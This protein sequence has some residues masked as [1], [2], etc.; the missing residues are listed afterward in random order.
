MALMA[1]EA[2][3]CIAPIHDSIGTHIAYARW[4]RTA[5]KSCIDRVD[6]KFLDREILIPSKVTPLNY[7]GADR[8]RFAKSRHILG[9]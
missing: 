5:F 7:P 8:K 4:V 2:G 9:C 3:I 1:A 6:Q